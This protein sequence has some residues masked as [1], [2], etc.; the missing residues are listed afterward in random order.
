MKGKFKRLAL[1]L[2]P[3]G[4]IIL[5][6]ITLTVVAFLFALKAGLIVLGVFLIIFGVILLL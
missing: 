3:I 5:G 2:L 6:A 4:L 1:F